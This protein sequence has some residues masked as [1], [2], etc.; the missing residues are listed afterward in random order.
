[1]TI[2]RKGKRSEKQNRYY[3]GVVIRMLT[4]EFRRLGNDVDDRMVHETC[5]KK[6]APVYIYGEGGEVLET[7]G[8]S[9]AL[10]NRDEMIQYI[11]RI[12][13]WC[14]E[15]LGLSIPAPTSIEDL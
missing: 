3:W 4:A 15:K 9:T 8:S 2:K 14:Q 13:F 7:V 11:D 12:V 1:M 6:F 10:M 5:T